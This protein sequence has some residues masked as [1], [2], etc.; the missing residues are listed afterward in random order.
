[1]ADEA[2][3]HQSPVNPLS[4]PPRPRLAGRRLLDRLRRRCPAD[5]VLQPSWCSDSRACY[6]RS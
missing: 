4:R 2:H 5:F 3:R 6:Q 1:M